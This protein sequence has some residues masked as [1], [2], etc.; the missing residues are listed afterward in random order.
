VST[1]LFRGGTSWLHRANPLT[2]LCGLLWAAT[3]AFVLPWPAAFALAAVLAAWGVQ[4][5]I[6]GSF[7]RRLLLFIGPLAIALLVIHGFLMHYPDSRA[8]GPLAFSLGG[9]AHALRILARLAAVVS[10]SFLF[11]ATTHP[12]DLLKSMD[13]SGFPPGLSYLV[14][15]PMLLAGMFAMRTRAIHDAQ[16]TRGLALDGSFWTRLRALPALLLPLV[17]VGLLEANQRALALH[18]RAFRAL[19]RRTVLD[20]PA[21]SRG[22]IW[23]RR[24]LVLA[25]IVQG[26]LAFWR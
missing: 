4:S 17:I 19:P 8:F 1:L 12:A 13:A 3:A 21:D 16:R 18:G 11:V 5:G 15:S 14:A 26:G 6:G 9:V 22:G 25:A 7:V 24:F 23:A 20:P 10:A 2:K